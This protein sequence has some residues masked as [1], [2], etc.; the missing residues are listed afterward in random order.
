M[1]DWKFDQKHHVKDNLQGRRNSHFILLL[2]DLLISTK[3]N[4]QGRRNSNFYFSSSNSFQTCLSSQNFIYRVIV[5]AI[6]VLLLNRSV[7]S[8]FSFISLMILFAKSY[9]QVLGNRQI[10]FVNFFVMQ[11]LYFSN[12]FMFTLHFSNIFVFS[13][14]LSNY[15]CV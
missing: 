9:L 5:I 14:C 10:N 12:I 11:L 15:V 3:D 4:L 1:F 6:C 7:Y 8:F 2:L 13:L